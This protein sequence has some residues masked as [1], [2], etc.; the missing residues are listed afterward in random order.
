MGFPAQADSFV[1]VTAAAKAAG[2]PVI[3][4][5]GVWPGADYQL[6]LDMVGAGAATGKAAGTWIE[7]T[8]G[9]AGPTTVALLAD[10]SADLGRLQ[11]EGFKQGLAE[12]G[13]D[14]T[15]V[16]LEASTRDAGYNAMQSNLIAH[17]DTAVI[18]GIG[19]DMVLGAR[20]ALI[21]AGVDPAD[22]RHYAGATDASGEALD[23]I[24]GGT[25]MWFES[26]AWSP[27]ELGKADAA[28]LIAAAEGTLSGNTVVRVSRVDATNVDA[29]RINAD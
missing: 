16:V 20:Q 23:L 27:T 1:P 13:A 29:Y 21:D 3:G 14:V 17:P 6:D 5:A 25:D 15:V 7:K 19:S 24:A 4:Y 22:G 26:Y 2:I 28:L 18:L 8:L 12:S 9:G 11:L 10:T